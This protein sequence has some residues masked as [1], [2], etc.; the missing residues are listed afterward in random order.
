V[1]KHGRHGGGGGYQVRQEA[2]VDDGRFGMDHPLE[3]VIGRAKG[4]TRWRMMTVQL[5][6]LMRQRMASVGC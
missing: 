6:I 2:A 4:E 1:A 5:A 3:L